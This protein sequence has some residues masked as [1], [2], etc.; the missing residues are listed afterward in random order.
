MT[1]ADNVKSMFK[2]AKDAYDALGYL[3]VTPAGNKNLE[4]LTANI[5][6]L[7]IISYDPS[8]PTVAGLKVALDAGDYAAFPANT[9]IPDTYNG[10]AFDWVVGHYGTATMSDGSTKEGVYLFAD[11]I[12]EVD[13]FGANGY[14]NQSIIHPWLNDTFLPNCSDTMKNIVGEIKV[15]GSDAAHAVNAKV[16]LM[17]VGEIMGEAPST[18]NGGGVAWDAW[19]IRTGLTTPSASLNNGRVMRYNGDINYWWTRSYESVT[20]AL[21]VAGT[22]GIYANNSSEAHGF[23]PALFIPKS[24]GGGN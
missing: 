16:W 20:G 17:S 19:K 10:E 22:G 2:H 15:T 11:K 7:P 24:A 12:V 14:Y 21:L 4:N 6:S 3:G 13:I 8:N 9:N 23:V 5:A 18:T 1:L